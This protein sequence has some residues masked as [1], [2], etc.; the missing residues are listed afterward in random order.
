MI[1]F[2]GYDCASV[3]SR[4]CSDVEHHIK[5]VVPYATYIHCHAHCLNLVLVDCV[6]TNS[7]ASDFPTVVQTLHAF[8]STSK[9][10]LVYLEIENHLHPGKKNRQLQ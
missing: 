3:M 10:Q 7:H 9:A 6:K 8:M 5:E 1:V 4:N 2:Q